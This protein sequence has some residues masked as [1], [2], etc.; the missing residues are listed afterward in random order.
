MKRRRRGEVVRSAVIAVVSTVVVFTGLYFA[1]T[2]APNWE[3]VKEQFFNREYF[4]DS[5]P[6]LLE[7]FWLNVKIF[8]IAEVLILPLALFACD[9]P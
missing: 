7:V 1:I 2:N 4:R 3:L 8:C 9:G 5:F 6:G